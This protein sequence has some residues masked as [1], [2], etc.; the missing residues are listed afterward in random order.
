MKISKDQLIAKI[1][2]NKEAHLKEYAEAVEAYRKEAAKQLK[3][4]T[5]ELKGGSLKI[6]LNLVTPVN[7]ADEYDKVI[8][9]FNWEVEETIELSQREFNEYVHDDNE[10]SRAARL[11]N[12]TYS[13]H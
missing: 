7:R 4:A 6:K 10:S 13:G 5:K 8:E 3:Q 2:E 9:M 12:S 1:K 11:M